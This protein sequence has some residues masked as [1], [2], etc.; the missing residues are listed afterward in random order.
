LFVCLSS[1]PLWFALIRWVPP[2]LV[3]CLVIFAMNQFDWPIT[4]KKETMEVPQNRR[5]FPFGWPGGERR[6]TCQSTFDAFENVLG[7]FGNI[8]GTHW[9]QWRKWKIPP[10]SPPPPPLLNPKE[11]NWGPWLHVILTFQIL[12][13]TSSPF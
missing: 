11:K 5:F 13:S 6:N 7:N 9:V 10:T 12:A 4:Q 3:L 1:G 2:K 8:V